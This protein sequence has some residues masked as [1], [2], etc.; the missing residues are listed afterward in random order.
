[1][2]FNPELLG[3]YF[4]TSIFIFNNLVLEP[5]LVATK[6]KVNYFVENSKDLMTVSNKLSVN[7]NDLLVKIITR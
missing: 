5:R 2:H 3:D 4:R 7:D 6:E 1:M